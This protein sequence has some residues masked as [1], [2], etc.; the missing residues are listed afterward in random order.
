MKVY[1]LIEIYH[2]QIVGVFHCKQWA[3]DK[4]N[5]EIRKFADS[6]ENY[7]IEEYWIQ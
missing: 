6:P 3:I 7:K 2:N 1:V 4:M 5:E